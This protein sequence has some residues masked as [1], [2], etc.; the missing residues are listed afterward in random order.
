MSHFELPAPAR[1]LLPHT[2]AMV[3]IDRLVEAGEE[4]GVCEAMLS[5]GHM[6][7]DGDGRMDRAGFVELA[8]QSYAALKGWELVRQGLP[9]PIG[10][11]VGAQGFE[12]LGDAFAGDRLRI[13]TASLGTFEG[14]GVVMA[15]I[16][17][18]GEVLAQG[19][20]K[21]FVPGTDTMEQA[22]A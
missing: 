18:E 17:R 6:L 3:Y 2:G 5:P 10:Y 14:F 20:I 7:L 1:Q 21:L 11:L 4:R 9:L 19:K 16:A 8:A 15:S 22:G 12:F 13:E